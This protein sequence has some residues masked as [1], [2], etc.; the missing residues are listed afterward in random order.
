MG[1][2]QKAPIS[3]EERKAKKMLRRLRALVALNVIAIA[4][5]IV[6]LILSVVDKQMPRTV[7][8]I[9]LVVLCA[10]E[11]S[12]GYITSWYVK[13]VKREMGYINDDT[14]KQRLTAQK[15]ASYK[16]KDKP[17]YAFTGIGL[18]GDALLIIGVVFLVTQI[19]I[20][21]AVTAIAILLG[22]SIAVVFHTLAFVRWGVRKNKA[23][24]GVLNIGKNDGSSKL[25]NK[26]D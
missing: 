14:A 9:V 15:A 2:K 5:S 3:P 24:K 23:E 7:Y 20:P 21:E 26:G 11:I 22:A 16:I 17:Y 12:V 6:V 4:L 13:K 10:F 1:K 19:K 25:N 8:G 18:F